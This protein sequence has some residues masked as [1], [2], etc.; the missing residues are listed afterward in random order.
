MNEIKAAATRTVLIRT[1]IMIRK[2][3]RSMKP[4][5]CN[6]IIMTQTPDV[7]EFLHLGAAGAVVEA[8]SLVGKSGPVL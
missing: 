2:Y 3:V 8:I 1:P 7:I 5:A 6:I 4:R